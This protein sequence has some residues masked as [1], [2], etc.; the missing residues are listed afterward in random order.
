MIFPILFLLFWRLGKNTALLLLVTIFFISFVYSI[1][2]P[3][4]PNANFL[5]LPSRAWELLAGAL[6]AFYIKK[7]ALEITIFFRF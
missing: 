3:V 1:L 2:A 7:K 6:V 4:H 5:L